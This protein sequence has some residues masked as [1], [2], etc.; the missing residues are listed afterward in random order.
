MRLADLAAELA[1]ARGRLDALGTG[2][3]TTDLRAVFSWSADKLSDQAAR[4]FRLLGLHQGPDISAAA[5][6]SLA[7]T[8]LAGARTALAELTRAS[9]LTEDAVGRFGCHDLLRA[10]AAELA[11]AT[12]SAAERDLASRRVLDY[13]LRTAH[14][15]AARLYPARGQV[16]LPAPAGGVTAEEFSRPPPSATTS[17]AGS[18]PGTGPRCC[19]GAA[20]RTRS[21][22]CSG[23][24]CWPRAG[25]VT[26]MRSLTCTASSA[27]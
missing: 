13:Y 24:R 22:R 27:M 8:T 6:A 16:S 1:D 2:E 18:S 5:A 10:Y 21:S 7:A 26:A 17:T 9:L 12:L 3:A 19:T 15:A 11:A 25:S 20:R 4:M 14:A 23:R